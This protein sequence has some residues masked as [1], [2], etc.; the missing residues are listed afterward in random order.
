MGMPGT[1]PCM[2]FQVATELFIRIP[3]EINPLSAYSSCSHTIRAYRVE[4][5]SPIISFPKWKQPMEF[6]D[7]FKR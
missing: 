7:L 6:T 1:T 5:Q 4:I 2:V 3:S